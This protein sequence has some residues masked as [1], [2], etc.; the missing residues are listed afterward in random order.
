MGFDHGELDKS[1]GKRQYPVIVPDSFSCV[2][3]VQATLFR[4]VIITSGVHQINKGESAK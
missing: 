3:M 4:V 1:L 2:G